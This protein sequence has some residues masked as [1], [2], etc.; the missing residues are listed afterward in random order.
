MIEWRAEG[1]S[2]WLL[3]VGV[4]AGIT[5]MVASVP[6]V[7]IAHLLLLSLFLSEVLKLVLKLVY[8]RRGM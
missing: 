5:G 8:Y 2:G 3:A 1:N 7:W 4:L 6:N